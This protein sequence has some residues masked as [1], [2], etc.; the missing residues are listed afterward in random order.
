VTARGEYILCSRDGDGGGERLHGVSH[1][2]PRFIGLA[3]SLKRHQTVRSDFSLSHSLSL[4]MILGE[5]IFIEG[6]IR[7]E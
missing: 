7:D 1:V 5:I 6:E 2:A 3:R 4:S